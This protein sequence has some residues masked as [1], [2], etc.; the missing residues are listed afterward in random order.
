MLSFHKKYVFQ[1][2]ICFHEKK[3]PFANNMKKSYIE[4]NLLSA[5]LIF[6]KLLVWSNFLDII[7]P[8]NFS[9]HVHDSMS[10]RHFHAKIDCSLEFI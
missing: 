1:G 3:F 9:H 7:Q 4:P 10:S 6:E 8:T 2:Q 5:G